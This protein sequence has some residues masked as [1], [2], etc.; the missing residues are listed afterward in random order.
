MIIKWIKKLFSDTHSAIISTF[1]VALLAGTGST[2]LFY[3]NLWNFLKT[4]MLLQTP[5]WVTTVSILLVLLVFEYCR[6]KIA[7]LNQ[8]SLPP[9]SL[10]LNDYDY[11]ENPGYYVHKQTKDKY[12]G[13]C[14]DKHNKLYRLSIDKQQGLMCR[15]CGNTY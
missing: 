2:Y 4:T 5:V 1:V 7:K 10:D 12:C 11:I 14:I 3:K 6:I 15:P 13:N 9:I 8:S